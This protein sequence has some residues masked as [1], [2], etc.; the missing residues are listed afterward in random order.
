MKNLAGTCL[1]PDFLILHLTLPLCLCYCTPHPSSNAISIILSLII[2][3]MGAMGPGGAY[4]A[5]EG[6]EDVTG[7]GWLDNLLV[8]V[9][10]QEL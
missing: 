6:E 8:E 3:Y 9:L 7:R 4:L 1:N 5:A 2:P 10:Q